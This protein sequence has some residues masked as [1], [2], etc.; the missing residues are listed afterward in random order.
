MCECDSLCHH[1]PAGACRGQKKE[2]NPLEL[3]LQVV[4]AE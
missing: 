4:G 3:E 2:L 1:M